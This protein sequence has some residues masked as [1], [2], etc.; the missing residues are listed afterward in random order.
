MFEICLSSNVVLAPQLH[1]GSIKIDYVWKE[2]R[3]GR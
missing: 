2:K 1:S 3:K